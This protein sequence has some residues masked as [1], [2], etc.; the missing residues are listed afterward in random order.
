MAVTPILQFGT[1]RFLQAHADLYLH[2]AGEGPV[3]VVQSSGDPARATRL[4]ALAHP[5]GYPVRVRGLV[6]GHAVDREQRVRSVARTLSTA[7][8]W[9]EICRIMCNEVRIVLSNTGDAGYRP[10]DADLADGFQQGMSYPA[11][12]MHLLLARFEGNPAP[13]Q[14]MPLE[15][16][17]D[18]GAVL[19][20]RVLDLAQGR[21]RDF[22]SWLEHEVVWVSSLVDRIVSEP[23]EPAGA[24]AEPYGLW[25][26]EAQ[27][28][29]IVPC[30]HEAV[31]V[32]DRLEPVAALK[33]YILNLGHTVMAEAWLR[34]G[35][36]PLVRE[37]VTGEQG[38]ALRELYETEIIPGFAA[39]GM[40]DEARA[41]VATTL[42]RFVNP[43]LDHRFADIAENHQEKIRRRAG[44]FL[45]WVRRHGDDRPKPRL[46]ALLARGMA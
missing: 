39:A 34:G 32:V 31:R 5:E 41:Y 27:E 38:A 21:S 18:N 3:T 17:T 30:R 23:L 19:K 29:L 9:P 26:I 33:L 6:D 25:A 13:V 15:L 46:E 45:D 7:T 11:K 20:A 40:E 1:S 2:E 12:L 14:V 4:A 44:A 16:I 36:P 10:S 43:F 24:V 35:V 37:A 28:R 42:E 8:D 22:R